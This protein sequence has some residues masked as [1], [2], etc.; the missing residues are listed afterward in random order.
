MVTLAVFRWIG[1]GFYRMS[2]NWSLVCFSWLRQADGFWEQDP[3][4][5]GPSHPITARLPCCHDLP[6]LLLTLTPWLSVLAA[7]FLPAAATA[8]T[9]FWKEV[10]LRSPHRRGLWSLGPGCLVP[11]GPGAGSEARP[12]HPTARRVAAGQPA[13]PAAPEEAWRWTGLD[14]RPSWT[15]VRVDGGLASA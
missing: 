3:R 13:A 15:W 10:T 9:P 6:L 14:L 2:P 5:K 7:A 1:Q 4:V 12:L 11:S 8:V